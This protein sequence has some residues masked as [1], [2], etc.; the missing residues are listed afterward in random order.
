VNGTWHSAGQSDQFASVVASTVALHQ[1]ASFVASSAGLV[2]VFGA[3]KLTTDTKARRKARVE[4]ASFVASS[5]GLVQVFGAPK[6]TTDTK[7]RTKMLFG[8]S[9]LR[10]AVWAL[11]AAGLVL[12]EFLHRHGRAKRLLSSCRTVTLTTSPMRKVRV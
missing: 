7:A 4:S 5:A 1:S 8:S 9:V 2:Q 10:C 12:Y 11:R 6:L 3:P